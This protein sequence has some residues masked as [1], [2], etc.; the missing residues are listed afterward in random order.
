MIVDLRSVLDSPRHFDFALE[1]DWWQD[2]DEA[3]QV[4]GLDGP[5]EASLSISKAGSEYLLGGRFTARFRLRCDRCL[6]P[7]LY[8]LGGDFRLSLALVPSDGGASEVELSEED[9]SVEF[10]TDGQIDLDDVIREQI[11][12]S[13]PM[14]CLCR[15][16]C[17]GL[18]PVCGADLNK[19]KCECQPEKGQP[20][21]SRLKALISKGD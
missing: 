21:F 6:E 1:A 18:C 7:Y 4:L 9:L 10:V 17:Q 15:E 3:G 2:N 16:D 14:K 8:D 13:L 11:Y 12:L 5:V 19:T 20:G